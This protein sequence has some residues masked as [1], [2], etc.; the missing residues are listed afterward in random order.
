MS[1]HMSVHEHSGITEHSQGNT[2]TGPV[3]K[4]RDLYLS[5]D[6][7][8]TKLVKVELARERRGVQTIHFLPLSHRLARV[9][10]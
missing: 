10:F 6:Q 5:Q 9:A 1:I 8:C 4:D 2:T 3:P 7:S